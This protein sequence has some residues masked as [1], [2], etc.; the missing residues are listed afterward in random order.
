[1]TNKQILK[2]LKKKFPKAP[3]DLSDKQICNN[4]CEK[5]GKTIGPELRK[6]DILQA[7]SLGQAITKVVR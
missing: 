1:M 7:R 3:P 6:I 5:Y 2:K 4:F